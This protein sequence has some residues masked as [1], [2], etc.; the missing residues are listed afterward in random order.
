LTGG[1]GEVF[2]KALYGFAVSWIT[3]FQP[4]EPEGDRAI[5]DH[6]LR[7]DDVAAPSVNIN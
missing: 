6:K 7:L 5:P 2:S 3:I 4:V 1:G